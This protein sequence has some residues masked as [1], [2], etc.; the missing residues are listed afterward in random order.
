MRVFFF[1]LLVLMFLLEPLAVAEP[2]SAADDAQQLEVSARASVLVDRAS[3]RVMYAQ[4]ADELLPIASTTKIM[5]ALLALEQSKPGDM[6]TA[7]Q[8]ASG[9]PGTSIYL[10]V[11][12]TLTMRDMLLGLMLRSGNDAAVAIAEHVA[13]S[14]DAFVRR[15]NKRAEE[16]GATAYFTNPHGL[17]QGGNGASALGLAKIACE[18]LKNP[19][20]RKLV[21]T[22]E[23][24]L[25]WAGSQYLRS[26]SNKNKLLKSY[27]GATGVKTGFTDL[28]GRCLV[29]SAQRDGMELVGVV[30]G[31]G[32]WFETGQTLLDWGF[33]NFHPVKLLAAGEIAAEVPVAGGVRGYACAVARE[34]FIVPVMDNER[35]ELKLELPSLAAPVAAGQALGTARAMVDGKPVAEIPLYA[36]D[37]VETRDYLSMFE[38]LLRFWRLWP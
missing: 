24:T 11:G 2:L 38:K 12:E 26:L 28:A 15:M 20:F 36:A 17:D 4:N 35:C 19:D 7:S 34:D 27:P 6:V 1:W 23:A 30:L 21:T 9:V 16:I 29:F 8:N 31:C 32:T 13:G 3:G 37:S 5:T 33:S 10:S 22:Q 14:V 25:P 18:A